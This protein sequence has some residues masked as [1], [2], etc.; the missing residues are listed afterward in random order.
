LIDIL[1]DA[2]RAIGDSAEKSK[3]RRDLADAIKSKASQ[4]PRAGADA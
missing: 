4:I 1:N 2:L 3:R